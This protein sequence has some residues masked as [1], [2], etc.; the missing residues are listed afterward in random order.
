MV[1]ARLI[2]FITLFIQHHDAGHDALRNVLTLI[3]A[4]LDY[5]LASAWRVIQVSI[6]WMRQVIIHN[7]G[8]CIGI[9]MVANIDGFHCIYLVAQLPMHQLQQCINDDLCF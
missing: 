8:I 3:Y 4:L 1:L 9:R 7:L 2:V 6:P 5:E